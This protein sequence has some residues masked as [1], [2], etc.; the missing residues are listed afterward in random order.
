MNAK[1]SKALA[2]QIIDDL[3]GEESSPD[4]SEQSQ[5]EDKT[6]NIFS[7]EQPQESVKESVYEPDKASHPDDGERTSRIVD[8]EITKTT[9]LANASVSVSTSATSVNPDEIGRRVSPRSSSPGGG[10]TEAYLSQAESLKLAQQKIL[11]LEEEVE[12]SRIQGE[13]MAAAA[14]TFRNR[15]DE[16]LSERDKLESQIQRLKEVFTE[17]KEILL[18][19]IES[20][21]KQVTESNRKIEEL[22]MRLSTNIHKIRVRE[23]ELENRLELVKIEGSAMLR[24]KD[25]MILDLKRQLDQL[26]HELENYRFKGQE[27][28]QQLNDKEDMLRRTVKALRIA[29]SMLEGSDEV[30]HIVK[31][32]KS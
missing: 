7:G 9:P 13:Q 32:A 26:N 3:L 19:T 17:E 5:A 12:R 11:E 29:L 2:D 10:V 14:E 24:S 18:A 6:K 23:R 25:E 30:H 20:K 21:E 16:L 8:D 27:L 22:Q 15:C 1:K 28:N 31:K 4:A